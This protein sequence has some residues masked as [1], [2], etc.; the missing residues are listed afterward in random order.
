MSIKNEK[1]YSNNVFVCITH[2][3]LGTTKPYSYGIP[4]QKA[5]YQ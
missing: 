1:G 5:G 4:K 2:D 3:H